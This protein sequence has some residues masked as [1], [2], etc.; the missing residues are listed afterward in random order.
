[1]TKLTPDY[2]FKKKVKTIDGTIEG[3]VIGPGKKPNTVI[4]FGDFGWKNKKTVNISD[5]FIIEERN[6]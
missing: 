6:R 4:V 2:Y 5:I 1:M 3:T